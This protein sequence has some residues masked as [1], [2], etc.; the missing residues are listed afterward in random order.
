MS[1]ISFL[2]EPFLLSDL[3]A[4]PPKVFTRDGQWI[5]LSTPKW[6]IRKAQDGGDFAIIDWETF[7]SSFRAD[8]LDQRAIYLLK[9]YFSDRISRKSPST[10]VNAYNW[11]LFFLRWLSQHS[12]HKQF[13]WSDLTEGICRNFLDFS[14]KNTANKGNYFS[15]LRTFYEWGVARQYQDFDRNFLSLMQTIVAVGN[16]K[17]HHVRFRDPVKG[18]F[19]PDEKRIL[20]D[21]LRSYLKS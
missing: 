5:D 16:A 21:A 17:G 9:L 10:A 7:N 19:S 2:N 12:D 18:P 8:L 14:I 20:T 3:P 15:C 11:L 4:L 1:Q 6:K 13:N